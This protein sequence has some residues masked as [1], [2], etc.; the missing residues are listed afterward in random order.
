MI[1]ICFLPLWKVYTVTKKGWTFYKGLVRNHENQR[2]YNVTY[3][4]QEN[5][6]IP[7]LTTDT[8]RWKYVCFLDYGPDGRQAVI[9]DM[10]DNQS[11]FRCFWDS[12][13]KKIILTDKDSVSFSYNELLDGKIELNGHWQGK[14]TSM[15]LT[16]LNV[17]NLNLVKDKFLFM[18]EDQ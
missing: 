2:L 18:Q 9:F 10:Q 6:V 3:Y 17:N 13:G 11:A 1:L 7:P 4:Q 12:L 5:D 14:N 16:R 8:V 15:Q